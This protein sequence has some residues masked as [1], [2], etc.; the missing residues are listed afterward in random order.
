LH[1]YDMLVATCFAADNYIIT[2][3]PEMRKS[4]YFK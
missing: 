2:S 1:Q 3:Q 4:D